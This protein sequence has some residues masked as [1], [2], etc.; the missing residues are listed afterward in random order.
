MKSRTSSQHR[1][2]AR[3]ILIASVAAAVLGYAAATWRMDHHH[4][5][6]P[7]ASGTTPSPSLSHATARHERTSSARQTAETNAPDTFTRVAYD[8]LCALPRT[9]E[10]ERKL[11]ALL[12]ELAH[13]DPRQAM[14]LALRQDNWAWRESLRDAVLRGWAEVDA[15]DAADWA[16]SLPERARSGAM[17]AVLTGAAA[18]PAQAAAVASAACE[19]DPVESANYGSA[20]LNA[21]AEHGAFAA[22]AR[23]VAGR[24]ASPLRLEQADTTFTLWA[25]NRPDEAAAAAAAINDPELQKAALHGVAVGWSAADPVAAANYAAQLPPGEA[26][27]AMLA[28]A[29][30]RWVEQDPIAAAG[31]LETHGTGPDFDMGVVAVATLPRMVTQRPDVAVALAQ[32]IS[33]GPLRLN[34]LRTLTLRW[35]ELDGAAATHFVQSSGV[36]S[37]AEQATILAEIQP[38]PGS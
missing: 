14:A 20:L 6:T 15:T 4:P 36:F 19:A 12:A 27:A 17:T 8:R 31:W 26:R 7:G 29:I 9:P 34:T 32:T 37:S 3:A 13:R 1:F 18:D 38:K 23:F 24:P 10:H 28:N 22:A 5:V 11:A 16:R 33:D 21:L 2:R 30:P 25:E 35:A